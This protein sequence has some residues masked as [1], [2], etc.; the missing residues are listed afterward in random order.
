MSLIKSLRNNLAFIGSKALDN[1]IDGRDITMKLDAQMDA[2]LGNKSEPIQ[3]G[4]FTN[5]LLEMVEGLWDEDIM[6][7]I[8]RVRVWLNDLAYRYKKE[9]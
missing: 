5:L 4:P 9:G 7:L 2:E 6:G 8:E 1:K 3:R